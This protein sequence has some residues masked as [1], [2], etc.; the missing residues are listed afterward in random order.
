M[1]AKTNLRPPLNI[2]LFA[3]AGGYEYGNVTL[4]KGEQARYSNSIAKA[5]NT[6]STMPLV[7]WFE[8]SA[9]T[10][11]AYSIFYV[12][13]RLQARDI[14]DSVKFDSNGVPQEVKG[15]DITDFLQ[16]IAVF[17]KGMECPVYVKRRDFDRSQLN[18]KS[19]I[20]E[21]QKKAIYGRSCLRLNTLFKSCVTDM[22]RTVKDNQL[23]DFDI[24]I[25]EENV[26][27]D[28]TLAFDTDENIKNFRQ[29]ML[30]A[31][32]AAEGQALRI[33]IVSG[34]EGN[35]ELANATKFSD[36]DFG[37]GETR[38]TGQP[39]KTIF[40][41][42]VL[43]VFGFDSVMYADNGAVGYFIVMVEKSFGQDNKDIRVDSEI[44]YIPDKKAYLMD[45]EIYNSTE[46]LNPEGVFIFKYK[47]TP[48][49]TKDKKAKSM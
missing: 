28:E 29:M 30:T 14:D 45:V 25:P 48:K 2:Q 44:N 5:L 10:K 46:L 35:A 24:T 20:I 21:A 13:G 8:E 3:G 33:G 43:K 9:S 22:K 31:Q 6:T 26:F 19:A 42:E 38:K 4:T 11:E 49:A 15:Q 1:G 27:G 37:D 34:I 47:R 17:P 16:S 36:R 32:E 7:G 23:T 40:G 39:L 41:G 18:E 12:S